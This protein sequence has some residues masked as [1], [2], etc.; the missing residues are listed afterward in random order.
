M[1]S[2]QIQYIMTTYEEGSISKAAQKLFVSQP[3]LSQSIQLAERELGAPIF[4]RKHSPL[5]LTYAGQRYIAAA[6]EFQKLE[7]NLQHEISDIQNEQCGRFRVGISMLRGTTI[8][9]RVL[10]AFL[11]KYPRVEIKIVEKGSNAI[12]PL[13]M[14]NI[15]D[16]AVLT[17]D[18]ISQK[19]MVMIPMSR[20]GIY[21]CAGPDTEL[22]KT[23]PPGTPV[24]VK[25]LENAPF[26]A[27][28]AGHGLHEIQNNIFSSLSVS[29]KILYEVD[30][31]VL[32]IR[33]AA[34]CGAMML[35]PHTVIPALDH[36]SVSLYPLIEEQFSRE[37]CLCYKHDTYLSQYMKDFIELVVGTINDESF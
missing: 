26:V 12:A 15:V 3:A 21:L 17:A 6:M 19:H 33:L 2:R 34:A 1:T 14:Q 28:K 22:A 29:P 24:S 16:I 9:P 35:C 30:S 7:L 20:E 18:M 25:V 13:I 37:L 31:A 8:L 4:D 11:Q 5:T 23:V 32:G 36:S 27:I 10:P